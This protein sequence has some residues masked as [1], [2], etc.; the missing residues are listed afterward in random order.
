MASVAT[1]SASVQMVS[2]VRGRLDTWCVASRR[3]DQPFTS[4][5]PRLLAERNLSIR[6]LARQAGVTDAHLSR[7]LRGVRYKTPSGDLARRVAVALDLPDDY[8]PEYREAFVIDKVRADPRL[9]DHL[10]R[11]LRPRP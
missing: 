11:K 9:R 6:A 10:Y 3:T 8:F 1:L 4:E 5:V 2:A 7:V